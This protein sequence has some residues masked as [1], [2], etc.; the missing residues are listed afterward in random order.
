LKATLVTADAQL[1]AELE[2]L[3][4]FKLITACA[5]FEPSRD[6]TDPNVAMRHVLGALARRWL[7]LHEE[8]KIGSRHLKAATKAV[9]PQLLEAFGIGPDIAAEL[10]VALGDNTDR[11]RFRSCVRQTVRRLSHPRI[12]RQDQPAPTQPRWQPAG[13]CRAAPSRHRADALARAN[14]RLRRPSHYRRSIQTRDHP[15]P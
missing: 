4:D 3:N 15:L 9:V 1:R 12:V 11:I 14:H 13:Q 7:A 8:I 10:L 6:L 2:P 5:T